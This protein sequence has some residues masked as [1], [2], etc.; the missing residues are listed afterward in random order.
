MENIIRKKINDNFD[1]KKL[2]IINN[3]SLHIG[4]LGYDSGS[5]THFKIII[6]I[7]VKDFTNGDKLSIKDK[8]NIQRKINKILSEEFNSGLH[9][10]EIEIIEI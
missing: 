6:N 8:L 1:V 7:D 3:S 5:D 4:H 9:A 2:I 10:L